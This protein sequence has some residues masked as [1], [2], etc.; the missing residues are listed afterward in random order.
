MKNFKEICFGESAVG[1]TRPGWG[2]M[3]GI[4]NITNEIGECVSFE[5]DFQHTGNMLHVKMIPGVLHERIISVI[6]NSTYVSLSFLSHARFM[7]DAEMFSM[8]VNCKKA[9]MLI[10]RNYNYRYEASEGEAMEIVFVA[11]DCGDGTIYSITQK[12]GDY[13]NG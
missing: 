2:L 7:D 8:E 11:K 1:A 9:R 10:N 13:G 4:I 6:T 12:C 3:S 5:A